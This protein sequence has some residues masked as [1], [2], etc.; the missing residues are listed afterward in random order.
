MYHPSHALPSGFDNN[1]LNSVLFKENE[2]LLFPQ[3]LAF[4]FHLKNCMP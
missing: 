2:R 4:K 3:E 1:Y